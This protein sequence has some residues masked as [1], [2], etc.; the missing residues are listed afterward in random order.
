MLGIALMWC[1]GLTEYLNG[2]CTY[3]L[4]VNTQAL[5]HTCR[6]PFTFTDK[7]EQKMFC[8]DI[9]MIQ[10]TSLVDGQLDHF[11]GSRSEANLAE[12]DAI[13]TTNYKFNGTTNLVQ[14]D[15]EVT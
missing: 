3:L 13:S 14:F 12:D 11:F 1:A 4:Q 8:T 7:T 5:K 2:L 10:A 6:D 15:A 9:M